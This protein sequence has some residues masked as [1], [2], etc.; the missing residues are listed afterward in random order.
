MSRRRRPSSASAHACQRHCEQDTKDKSGSGMAEQGARYTA[1]GKKSQE[2]GGPW[3]GHTGAG[4]VFGVLFAMP[5][6][7]MG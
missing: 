4:L 2:Y 7:G 6:A 1:D 3:A 5:L